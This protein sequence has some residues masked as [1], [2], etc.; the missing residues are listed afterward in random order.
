MEGSSA[1]PPGSDGLQIIGIALDDAGPVRAFAREHL[2]RYNDST[3][4]FCMAMVDQAE[5][6]MTPGRAFGSR[7]EGYVRMALVENELRLKQAIRQ[8]GRTLELSRAAATRGR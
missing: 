3:E 1:T 6:A 7:G 5:V 2:A 4:E 8:I